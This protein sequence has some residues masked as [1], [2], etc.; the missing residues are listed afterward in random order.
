ML[1]VHKILCVDSYE[2]TWR[3]TD[4]GIVRMIVGCRHA[5]KKIFPGRSPIEMAVIAANMELCEGCN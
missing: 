4:G 3:L 1:E 5:Q 2:V